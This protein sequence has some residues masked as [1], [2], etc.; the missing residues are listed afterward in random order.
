[1]DIKV[2]GITYSIVEKTNEEMGGR[3][4]LADF[5][6]QLIS[7]NK[8]FTDQTKKIAIYHEII[9]ILSEAYGLNL[10]ETQVKIGTHA[11]LAF[12]D[13]NSGFSI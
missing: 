10:T 1:M 3:L 12:L 2:A 11:L 13:D 5:N 6:S 8:D 9:H 4:G 7:I